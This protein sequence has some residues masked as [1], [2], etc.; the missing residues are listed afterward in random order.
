MLYIGLPVFLLFLQKVTYN[1]Q[2]SIICVS[3][4]P[5]PSLF[6]HCH[7]CISVLVY[8][9]LFMCVSM[10]VSLYR[11]IELFPILYFNNA[12]KNNLAYFAILYLCR[13]TC[14]I[15]YQ[16]GKCLVTCLVQ[17]TRFF[18]LS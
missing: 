3:F 18:F 10:C 13:F 6:P 11:A 4:P 12:T 2:S 16:K 9:V 14:K 17:L 8:G 15:D 5:L 1:T 7:L